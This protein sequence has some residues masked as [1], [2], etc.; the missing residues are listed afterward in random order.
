MLV[1]LISCG[2]KLTFS[3]FMCF[4][5]LSSLYV[6]LAWIADWKGLE[7]FLMATLRNLPSAHLVDVSSA[8]QT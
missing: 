7:I 5:I 1:G 8:E 6:L 2:P 4:N 3:W